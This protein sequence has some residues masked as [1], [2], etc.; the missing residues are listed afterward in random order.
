VINEELLALFLEE[1][2]E[3]VPQIGKDLR[4]WRANPQDHEY[5]DSLQRVLHTLKGSARMAGLASIGDSVHG[6]ED[7]VIRALNHKITADDF[8][9]MFLEFDQISLMLDQV[10]SGTGV[11]AAVETSP[12]DT[13]T[14][15]RT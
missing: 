9:S 7:H 1:A 8:D 3:L 10:T 6:M 4:G 11:K 12:G 2:R 15:N 14:Q 13:C 5:I